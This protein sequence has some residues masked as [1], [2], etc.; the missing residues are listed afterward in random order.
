MDIVDAQIHLHLTMNEGE[1]IAAM[2]SLGIQAALIDEFWGYEGDSHDPPPG[3]KLPGGVFRPVAPG[4]TMASMKHPDRFSWLLRID[5]HDPDLDSQMDQVKA[6]PQGRA[7]RLEARKDEEV[8]SLAAGGA[9]ALFRAAQKHDLPV[10]ILTM[11]NS[12][13]LQPYVEACPDL[14]IVIDHCGLP[15]A[16]GEFDHVLDL[17]RHRNVFLKWGH[18]PRVFGATRYPFPEVTPYLARALDAFGRE[19][20]MWASDFTA[21]RAGTTWADALFYLRENPGLSEGDKEWL[22]GRSVRTLLGW[23]AP[24]Q[25]ARPVSHRH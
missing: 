13:L 3:Y 20:I 2:D 17:A 19:R 15:R 23:P 1:A 9:M 21:L 24:A 8:R 11:G 7:I 16:L 4:A 5:P 10:F 6:A 14:R 12:A 25:P 18:A 22:L